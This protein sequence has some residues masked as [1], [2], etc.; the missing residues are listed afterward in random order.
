M[1]AETAV[2]VCCTSIQ[3]ATPSGGK[4]QPHDCREQVEMCERHGI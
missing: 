4:P 2:N 1:S 3:T